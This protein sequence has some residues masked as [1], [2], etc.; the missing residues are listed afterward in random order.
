[1]AMP[2]VSL[3]NLCAPALAAL[4][5]LPAALHAQTANRAPAPA[6]KAAAG[7]G[8]PDPMAPGVTGSAR[9]AA[10]LERVKLAQKGMRTMEARFVQKQESAML[11]QPE[12]SRG[13]F[14]YQ[15]PDRVRWEYATPN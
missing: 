12:E 7:A 10:L 5:L 2:R 11:L 13:T 14:S 15:A 1:M 6:P 9:L 3:R 4:L 8:T